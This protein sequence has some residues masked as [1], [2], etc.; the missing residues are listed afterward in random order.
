MSLSHWEV[1]FLTAGIYSS[2]AK[3]YAETFVRHNV[4]DDT[5][6]DLDKGDLRD[7]GITALGDIK[8]IL[9]HAKMAKY[10]SR[11]V[12][13]PVQTKYKT[14]GEPRVVTKKSPQP[15]NVGKETNIYA[16][17]N[18]LITGERSGKGDCNYKTTYK[19]ALTN[20]NVKM[21]KATGDKT[22]SKVQ[23]IKFK[24]PSQ[25]DDKRLEV[26]MVGTY[27]ISDD[28]SKEK[29]GK[30]DQNKT[31]RSMK[32]EENKTKLVDSANISFNPTSTKDADS[33]KKDQANNDMKEVKR[34]Q[35]EKTINCKECSFATAY[36][37]SLHRHMN[38]VH[39]INQAEDKTN[40]YEFPANVSIEEE[41]TAMTIKDQENDGES[42]HDMKEVKRIHK[43]KSINCK[44]CSFVTTYSYSLHRHMKKVHKINQAIDNTKEEG[45]PDINDL[46]CGK[47]FKEE[48]PKT[49][50]HVTKEETVKKILNESSMNCKECSFITD[51]K[52]TLLRHIKGGHAFKTNQANDKKKGKGISLGSKNK[53]SAINK[54]EEVLED[55]IKCGECEYQTSSRANI[56]IHMAEVHGKGNPWS[57]WSCEKCNFRTTTRG[58]LLNHKKEIHNGELEVPPGSLQMMNSCRKDE[59]KVVSDE[60]ESKQPKVEGSNEGV[61]EFRCI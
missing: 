44:E 40:I 47:E 28:E 51:D 22:E 46:R 36:N 58:R 25:A 37:Y 48:I 7:M 18:K 30:E 14:V 17:E 33:C 38:K 23:E 35:K 55:I 31:V 2:E 53:G 20:H 15:E 24:S 13:S 39:K 26:W 12:Q 45:A 57:T 54:K 9:K 43:E 11:A 19:G 52:V 1:Y 5:L 8:R 41:K 27:D 50:A 49:L 34:I 59:S 42:L 10:K 21:H 29:P 3:T 61:T 32:A 4:R 6:E 60:S 56:Q 16:S